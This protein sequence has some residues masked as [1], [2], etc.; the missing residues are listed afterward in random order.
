VTVNVLERNHNRKFFNEIASVVDDGGEGWSF[1]LQA[2]A[3]PSTTLRM[4]AMK[5]T[6]LEPLSCALAEGLF[7][8]NDII[9]SLRKP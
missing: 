6:V 1:L 8:I 4:T 3:S 9:A 7:Y 2:G 5:K